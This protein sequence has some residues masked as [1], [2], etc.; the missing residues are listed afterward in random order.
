MDQLLQELVDRICRNLDVRDLK[1]TLLFS[2]KFQFLSESYSEIFTR[3]V[4]TTST[5]QK[6]IS[7]YTSHRLLYL[8]QVEFRPTHP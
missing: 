5:A 7:T 4:L 6:F 8:C 2:R 3:R 1:T